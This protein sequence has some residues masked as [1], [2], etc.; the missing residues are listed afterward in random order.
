MAKPTREFSVDVGQKS[1][2][3]AGPDFIERDLDK[4]FA[5]FDPNKSLPTGEQGGIGSENMKPGA[6]TAEQTG[7][8]V[9][10]DGVSNPGGNVDFVAGTGMEIIPDSQN[11]KITFAAKNESIIPGPHAETHRSSGSDPITPEDIG[12]TAMPTANKIAMYDPLERLSSGAAPSNDNHV[13]RKIDMEAAK[14]HSLIYLGES[15]DYGG[16]I[17][18]IAQDENYIYVGGLVTNKVYKLNK[19]N[20]SKVAERDYGGSIR[21]IAQDENYLYVGGLGTNKVHKLNK[22]D[23]S[24]V[25]ESD[26]YGGVIYALAQDENYIYVGGSVTNKVYKLNKTNLTKVVESDGYGGPIYAIAVD[27]DYLYVGGDLTKKV[28]KLNKTNLTKVTESDDYGEVIRAI[29]IDDD[30]V[31]IGGDITNKIYKFNK[32]NLSKVAESTSYGGTIHAIAQDE[33]Y[34]YVG[35]LVTNKVYKLNK[36]NLSKVAERDYGGSIRAIAQD[37]NYL[38]VGGVVTNKVY[39]LL[40]LISIE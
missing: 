28:Y 36:T 34:I 22:T 38:Y 9:S 10:V 7:A 35:G 31:Y 12:A 39:K 14:K 27:D 19:T 2:G 32:T 16:T 5:M 15:I 3:V 29:A 18:A 40:N 24:K 20:L 25:A 23:L 21:A 37:E 1:M 30:F 17:H 8:L 11:K 33:N 6:V 4:L 13:V 26:D